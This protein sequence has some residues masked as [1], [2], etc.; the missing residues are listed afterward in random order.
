VDLVNEPTVLRGLVQTRSGQRSLVIVAGERE[1]IPEL[2]LLV[3]GDDGQ[4]SGRTFHGAAGVL[5]MRFFP[6]GDGRT[7]VEIIPELQHGEPKQELVAGPGMFRYEFAP[8]TEVFHDL[9]LET[10][11]ALGQMILL[12]CLPN[13][14]GSLG[15]HL[16]TE[17]VAGQP[18]QQKMLLFRLAH[19][20][21][22]DRYS[23]ESPPPQ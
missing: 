3:R 23:T 12:T 16:F 22:D 6:Q 4:V 2:A 1:R 15:H 9:R 10:P 21:L 7:R 18:K 13:R 19:S 8:P 20:P 14:P 17:E 11:L 5:A